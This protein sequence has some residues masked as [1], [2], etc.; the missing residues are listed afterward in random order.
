MLGFGMKLDAYMSQ[1]PNRTFDRC[2]LLTPR[3]EI[4]CVHCN[5]LDGLQL[6]SLKEKAQ[7]FKLSNVR[8]SDWFFYASLVIVFLFALGF[9]L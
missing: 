7:E 8:L 6:E 2:G 9:L 1:K 5:G 3:D 4:D